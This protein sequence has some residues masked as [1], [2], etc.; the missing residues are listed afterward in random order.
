MNLGPGEPRRRGFSVV[1]LLVA[2]AIIVVLIALLTVAVERAMRGG[3]QAQTEFLMGSIEQGL[4][5]FQNDHGY[6]PPVLGRSGLAGSQPAGQVGFGRDLLPPP[7]DVAG[8]QQWGSVT[9][10]AEYLLGYGD[11][12][13]DGYGAVGE[14]PYP[15]PN[16]PGASEIPRL[17]FRS[18]GRDGVWNATLNPRSTQGLAPG[19]YLARNPDDAFSGVGQGSASNAPRV[20]GRVF[21]PY[22]ELKDTRVLGA[23]VGV[24]AQGTPIIALP[25]EVENFDSLPKAILDYWGSPIRYYRR[26]YI[27]TDPRSPPP[28]APG[29]AVALNLGDVFV[30]RPWEVAVGRDVD[31][32]SDFNPT[33]PGG[34]RTTTR[35]LVGANFALMSAGP[36]RSIDTRYRRDPEGR[37][38]DNLTRVGR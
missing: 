20:A 19:V 28:T 8:Q 29:T 26:P 15:N 32:A 35:E 14:P 31:G 11:R 13:A 38:E 27:G 1:E 30:L 9:T 16:A 17:G 36:D 22:I 23:V 18:P 10:L 5:T 24:D 2:I 33:I 4:A 37:N 34:D 25:G 21:G 3:Q 7:S 6:L 12:S